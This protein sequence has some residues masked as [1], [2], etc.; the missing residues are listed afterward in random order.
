MATNK[1]KL[2]HL[3]RSGEHKF[4]EDNYGVVFI[5]K[6]A[7]NSE[8]NQRAEMAIN[9]DNDIQKALNEETKEI[10]E[11]GLLEKMEYLETLDIVQLRGLAKTS[12]SIPHKQII[13]MKK[14]EIVSELLK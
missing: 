9:E 4:L 12:L 10:K 1:M 5:N 13:K 11:D 7:S 8:I 2:R 14:D 6:D 3:Y